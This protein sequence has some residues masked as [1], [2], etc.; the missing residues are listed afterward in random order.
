[1]PDK[2]RAERVAAA[3]VR[4]T[5]QLIVN[6][7]QAWLAGGDLGNVTQGARRAVAAYLE[8]AFDDVARE[9]RAAKPE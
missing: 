8:E 2:N 1:M 5:T 4:I 7:L 6:A 3:V 9:A